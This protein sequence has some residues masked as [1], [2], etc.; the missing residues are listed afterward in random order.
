MPKKDDFDLGPD[1]LADQRVHLVALLEEHGIVPERGTPERLGESWNLTHRYIL[2]EVAKR[3]SFPMTV[4][5][6]RAILES[7]RRKRPPTAT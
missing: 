7:K 2:Q 1:Q 4:D 6:V 3:D 5:D